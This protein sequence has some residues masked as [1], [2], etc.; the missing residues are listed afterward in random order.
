[1][2][3]AGRCS[4]VAP[5]WKEDA[6]GDTASASVKSEMIDDLRRNKDAFV[7]CLLGRAKHFF[8]HLPFS[9]FS[10]FFFFPL[11]LAYSVLVFSY[12]LE[13]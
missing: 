2:R 9:S 8:L 7:G 4:S 13:W 11:F 6:C 5:A 12:F 1:V 10:F 3:Q